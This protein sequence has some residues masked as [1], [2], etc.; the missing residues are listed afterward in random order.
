MLQPHLA[1]ALSPAPELLEFRDSLQ[2][3]T[4]DELGDSVHVV[5]YLKVHSALQIST[6]QLKWLKRMIDSHGFVE[7]QDYVKVT[8]DPSK[9]ENW[10]AIAANDNRSTL[11]VLLSTDVAKEL[12]MVQKTEL[13]RRVRRY[14]ILAE[15]VAV[16]YAL[17]EL[18]A[19]INQSEKKVQHFQTMS[20]RNQDLA[21]IALE[22]AGVKGSVTDFDNAQRAQQRALQATNERNAYQRAYQDLWEHSSKAYALLSEGRNE[23]AG[24]A[25][26]ALHRR[27]GE[28][29]DA[30]RH[31]LPATES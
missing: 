28:Y 7:G 30:L 18:K 17:D 21:K 26:R 24:D 23:R 3:S 22:K 19:A 8:L 6:P 9:T 2:L 31:E 20:G 4:V 25:L 13:G 15:K 29:S 11:T 27:Y 5:D 14:F 12:A 1:P 10:P 16:K